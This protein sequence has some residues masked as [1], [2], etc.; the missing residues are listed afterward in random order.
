VI[1]NA[2]WH[3]TLVKLG[4]I[5]LTPRSV[6]GPSATSSESAAGSKSNTLLRAKAIQQSFATE[7]DIA[8]IRYQLRLLRHINV[9]KFPSQ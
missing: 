2:T 9:S 8:N 1:T 6:G 7:S 3:G 4:G 5:H